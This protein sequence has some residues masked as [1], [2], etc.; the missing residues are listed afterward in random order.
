M[1][2]VKCWAQPLS[3]AHAVSIALPMFAV[4][5]SNEVGILA[6]FVVSKAISLT[7][8]TFCLL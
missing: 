3:G 7:L 4:P 8:V 5:H 2:S 6:Y 1:V